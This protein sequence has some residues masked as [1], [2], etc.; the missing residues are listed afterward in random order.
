MYLVQQGFLVLFYKPQPYV[1]PRQPAQDDLFCLYQHQ[2][3]L[4]QRTI[5]SVLDLTQPLPASQLRQRCLRR[6]KSQN[7]VITGSKEVTAYMQLVAELYHQA[8]ISSPTHTAAEMQ[9]LMQAFPENIKLLTAYS[10]QEL[11]GGVLLFIHPQAVNLQYMATSEVGKQKH[12]LDLLIHTVIDTYRNKKKYLS[13]GSSQDIREP[14]HLNF[15]LLQN[16][17]SY[18]ARGVVQDTYQINFLNFNENAALL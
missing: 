17:S 18:G 12:A 13:F 9:Y 5:L 14:Y 16:K 10:E 7:L 11:V 1:Y 2:A 8:N 4:T 6:A 3:F 15:N